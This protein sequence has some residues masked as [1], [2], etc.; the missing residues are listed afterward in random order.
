[1]IH[2]KQAFLDAQQ[3][4]VNAYL[5]DYPIVEIWSGIPP[6]TPEAPPQ[7]VQVTGWD[8]REE[9]CT[10]SVPQGTDTWYMRRV[11]AAGVC[12]LLMRLEPGATYTADVCVERP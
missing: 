8:V 6:P 4:S 9:F 12:A 5:V 10:I 3:Q 7:G 1:M 11:N 2:V